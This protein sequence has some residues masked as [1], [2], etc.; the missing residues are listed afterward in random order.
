MLS[1][2]RRV[3]GTALFLSMAILHVNFA[4]A[5]LTVTIDE[6]SDHWPVPS[7]GN[8]IANGPALIQG[9]PDSIANGLYAS[10]VRIDSID[11]F[12]GKI[13][14]Q[15]FTPSTSFKL[16]AVSLYGYGSGTADPNNQENQLPL[17]VHLY[18]LVGGTTGAGTLPTSY[19]LSTANTDNTPAT[20]LLGNGAGLTFQY[21]GSNFY[22][23]VNLNFSGADQ[24]EL[25]AGHVYSFEI[26]GNSS[27]QGAFYPQILAAN[28][29]VN[30]MGANPYAGGDGYQAVNSALTTIR[31]RPQ[32]SS[33]DMMI[34]I[35]EA[36]APQGQQGD[37]D[38]DGDV[39]GADFVAW[40]THFP[41]QIG[42]TLATGDAD[43]DQDVDAVDFSIWQS[44]FP[45][46]PSTQVAAVPEPSGAL[47]AALAISALLTM[48]PRR[49]NA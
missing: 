34:A 30:S 16:G 9:V 14:A 18:E 11:L 42:A 4:R 28:A 35:Y 2:H 44:N 48:R 49:S 13:A 21:G 31:T 5:A 39:D 45:H 19:N 27:L 20:D 22:Q 26:S 1:L 40:Q 32:N 46:E 43:N 17:G 7:T 38:G 33:R 41:T 10:G 36:V 37:F 12:G 8:V 29:D 3:F 15:T 23:F 47:L 24:I 6:D 25:Q